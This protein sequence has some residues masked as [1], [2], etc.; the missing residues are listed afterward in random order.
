[1]GHCKAMRALAIVHQRDAGAGVFAEALM[2]RG[3]ELDCW[4]RAE[5]GTPPRDPAGYDAVMVF[6]GA[7]NTHQED[8][9]PWLRE[10][11]A[12]LRDL[13]EQRV[14][15]LGVCLGAQLLAEAAGARP[16]R[17]SRPEI[18]WHAVRLSAGA[19][20][21]PLL[22]PLRPGFEAFQWHSY[23]FPLPPG[24]IPLAH[25]DV[26]LQACRIGGAAWAIQFHAEVTTQIV[27][28]WI[29]DYRSDEDAA[30]LDP[31]ALRQQTRH[32]IRAWNEL[33]RGLCERFL[34]AARQEG[35]TRA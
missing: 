14:P 28:G 35:P 7:M 25:S 5:T 24:A 13:L 3:V 29:D 19:A 21:D 16:R 17:A 8:R 11:K 32:A 27:D 23:E 10:E 22:G 15:L 26:C 33:G 18:G 30:D 2:E 12:L 20:D 6:G 31:D 9:Y 34:A 4:L 1:M